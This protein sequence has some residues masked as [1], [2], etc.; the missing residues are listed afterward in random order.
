[1]YI[2]GRSW[3]EGCNMMQSWS[4]CFLCC[5]FLY[6]MP[7]NLHAFL[8]ESKVMGSRMVLQG[9]GSPKTHNVSN[10]I[11]VDPKYL[12]K[13]LLHY[14]SLVS[15]FLG[16]FVLY[17]SHVFGIRSWSQSFG[18]KPCGTNSTAQY[19]I[20][21]MFVTFCCLFSATAK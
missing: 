19:C 20:W 21:G 16:A 11:I 18:E 7:Q 13:A 14:T 3:K 1:M 10:D 12:V 9:M 6:Q 15:P 8:Q 2:L 4:H 17:C 5:H